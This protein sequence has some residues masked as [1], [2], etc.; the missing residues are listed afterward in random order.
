MNWEFG[1]FV[2]GIGIG[3]FFLPLRVLVFL[4]FFVFLDLVDEEEGVVAP[5]RRGG[6]INNQQSHPPILA[7]SVIILSH[8]H[9]LSAPFEFFMYLQNT[10]LLC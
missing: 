10:L 5:D 4:V 1:E 9:V 6:A 2:T 7:T 8:Q 3:G